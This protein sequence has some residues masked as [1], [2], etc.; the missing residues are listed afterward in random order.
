LPLLR[1]QPPTIVAVTEPIEQR[2]DPLV[3]PPLAVLAFA[4][5]DFAEA[6]GA[7][8]YS[9]LVHHR[10]HHR[11]IERRTYQATLAQ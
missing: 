1:R 10:Y 6:G 9:E 11:N 8:D 4:A 7:L 2:L 5:A 3:P